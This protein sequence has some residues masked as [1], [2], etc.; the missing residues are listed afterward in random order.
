MT[1]MK[2]TIEAEVDANGMFRRRSGSL[3]SGLA[4]PDLGAQRA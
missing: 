4:G 3:A 2:P 1:G